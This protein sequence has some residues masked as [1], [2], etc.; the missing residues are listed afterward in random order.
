VVRMLGETSILLVVYCF[1]TMK[2]GRRVECKMREKKIAHVSL[3][4]KIC[5]PSALS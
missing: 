3:K 1:F 4:C 5:E 2:W